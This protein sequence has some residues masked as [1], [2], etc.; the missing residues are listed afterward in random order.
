MVGVV[1]F[2]ALPVVWVIVL[3]FLNY[4]LASPTSLAGIQ[5]YINIFKY[6]GAAHS[7]GVTAYYV[8][9]NIPAQTILALGLAVMIDRKRRGMGLYRILFVAPYLS[10]PVAMGIIWYWV[11]DPK[12]GAVN[13]FLAFSGY[14][15]RTGYPL[16]PGPCRWWPG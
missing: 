11:F 8:L 10:T 4:N 14:K 5:N 2:L 1:L 12:L 3:S 9:L 16:P 6:D 7:L 15:A 13:H